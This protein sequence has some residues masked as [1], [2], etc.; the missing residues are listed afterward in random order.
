ME[1]KVRDNRYGRAATARARKRHAGAAIVYVTAV[2]PVLVGVCGLAV[3]VGRRQLAR[4]ELQAVADAAARHAAVGT[5]NSNQ[6]AIDAYSNALAVVNQSL[7][8]GGTPTLVNAD[9]K[10]GTWSTTNRTFTVNGSGDVV[11]VTVKQ[12][13]TRPG[14]AKLFMSLFTSQQAEISCTAT[15]RNMA[16][17]T[18]IAPPA[19]GNLW[20]SGMPYNTTNKNFRTDNSELWDNSGT[21]GTAK[22]RP[23]E[24]DLEALGL[25]AGDTIRLEGVT[26]TASW[27]SN[28]GSNDADGDDS[29]I[30]ANGVAPASSAPTNSNNGMS[31]TRAPI[32]GVMAVFLSDS[33]PTSGTTPSNLDFN[34]N[35]S[36]DYSSISPSLKQVFFVGDGL[37][38]SGTAQTITIPYGATRVFL[39]MMDAWQWNDNTGNF[40]TRLYAGTETQLLK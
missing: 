29:Y 26:G 40:Q 23:L 6:K 21:A 2:M 15:A 31:N 24:I 9:V 35:S 18:T 3:D 20:L 14:A 22:Q 7:V 30:V 17:Y 37:R 16:L 34:S 8:D 11:Q 1:K 5:R 39:G 36:R 33:A 19:S 10:L 25:S 4:T 32:G 13:L 12:K 27:V 28:G 38:S